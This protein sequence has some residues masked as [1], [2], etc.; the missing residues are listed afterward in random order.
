MVYVVIYDFGEYSERETGVD[1]VFKTKQQ[2]VDFIHKEGFTDV[3]EHDEYQRPETR[4][5]KR[6]RLGCLVLSY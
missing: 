5:Q 3:N 1:A 4:E 6:I 2:A